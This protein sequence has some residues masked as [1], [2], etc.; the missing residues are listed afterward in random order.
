MDQGQVFWEKYAEYL[1]F[2]SEKIDP[3]KKFQTKGK[4]GDQK[5]ETFLTRNIGKYNWHIIYG[6]QIC[7][8]DI[9]Y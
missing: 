9:M 3:F 5:K 8:I 4:G 1:H 2:N 6:I 7:I